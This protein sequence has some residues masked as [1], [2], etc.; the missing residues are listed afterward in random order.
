VALKHGAGALADGGDAWEAAFG[1]ACHDRL[2][3]DSEVV[4]YWVYPV[5]NGANAP[6]RT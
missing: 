3:T 6:S 1:L 5:E 2:E 4:P